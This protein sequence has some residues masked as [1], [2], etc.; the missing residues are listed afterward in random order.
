MIEI[1]LYG[2]STSKT[3]GKNMV[4]FYDFIQSYINFKDK[5]KHF[6]MIKGV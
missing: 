6:I 4:R 3:Q 2:V 5:N 1:N